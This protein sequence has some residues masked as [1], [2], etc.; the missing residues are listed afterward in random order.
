MDI[1]ELSSRSLSAA[2][3]LSAVFNFFAFV[4][5]FSGV[6]VEFVTSLE[7][8]EFLTRS[9]S[10]AYEFLAVFDFFAA[11]VASCERLYRLGSNNTLARTIRLLPTTFGLLLGDSAFGI[12]SR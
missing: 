4:S 7:I 5:P 2:Y 12:S 11:R 8:E 3:G 1:E 10:A 6:S 9:L